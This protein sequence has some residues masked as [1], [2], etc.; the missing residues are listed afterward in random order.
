[1]IDHTQPRQKLKIMGMGTT[2]EAGRQALLDRLRETIELLE[3]IAT[4]RNLLAGLPDEDRARLLRAVE[5][6][7]NPD[8]RTLRR[9]KKATKRQTRLARVNK[10][11]EALHDTGIRVLRRKP[12]VTTPN[13]F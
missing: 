5:L 2:A 6:V 3:S 13:V 11:D 7:N 4:N 12:V 9:L 10:A 1:M 8:S